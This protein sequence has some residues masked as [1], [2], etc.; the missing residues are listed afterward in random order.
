[1]QVSQLL[2]ILL[3]V[4]GVGHFLGVAVAFR[5]GSS[6]NWNTDSWILD[7]WTAPGT[8]RSIAA[9]LF[10]FAALG[11]IAAALSARGIIFEVY[12]W[13]TLAIVAA[14]TSLVAILLFPDS[15][16]NVFNRIAAMLLNIAIILTLYLLPNLSITL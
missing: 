13:R 11:S 14:W 4:H 1:M 12:T 3:V 7:K 6:S 16:Y 2:L 5:K 8:R 9:C 10:I 15:L